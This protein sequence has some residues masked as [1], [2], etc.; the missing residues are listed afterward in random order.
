[1]NA[2]EKNERRRLGTREVISSILAAVILLVLLI[3]NLGPVKE[4]RR[5]A[6][7]IKHLK[8]ISLCCALYADMNNGR[9]PVNG[10]TPTLVGS[11]RL[12]SNVVDTASILFCPSD[13][14][15]RRS[16]RA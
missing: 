2:S 4:A 14:A 9:C 15:A 7:C 12:L 10:P 1:M 3:V 13:F 6:G 5:R 11:L 16:Y 8:Y